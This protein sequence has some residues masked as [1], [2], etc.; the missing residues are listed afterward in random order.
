MRAVADMILQL[1]GGEL[2][3][4]VQEYP[5][6]QQQH[7]VRVSLAQING[8]L[9]TA[10]TESEV[11]EVFTQLDLPHTESG[12]E[13]EVQPPVERLDLLIAEDL[14]EEVARIQG[15]DRIVSVELSPVI[16]KPA[17]NKNFYYS[18]R[19]RRLLIEKGFSEIFSP[20]FTA[21]GE[22]AVL[23]KVES[24]TPFLRRDLL[25]GLRESLDKNV[26]NKD[27]FGITQVKLFEI[28]TVWR[29]GEESVWL[30][31]AVEKVK[32]E[33]TS[34]DY[35]KEV[36]EQLGIIIADTLADEVLEIP[37]EAFVAALPEAD[38]YDAPG[39]LPETHYR[40]FSRYP[41]IVRDIALWTPAETKPEEVLETIRSASGDLLLR[42]S[43]FDQFEKE[44]KV[45][46][47]YRLVFQSFDR[48][49]TDE[50]ANER[51]ESV[52]HAVEKKGWE[53]R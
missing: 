30:G 19:I 48:T 28:G 21:D 29:D 39:A 37:L 11:S 35:L 2:V 38:A 7:P 50:D 1:A 46:Y 9:G 45:S 31:V 17:I 33:K 26:R 42:I 24:D 51:M 25:G 18:E 43:L 12:G 16:E 32:K 14:I 49:L 23:N 10:F 8:A 15:Y 5:A 6:R 53:V 4:F 22:V 41:F 27:L 3:G 34:L 52:N 20:V 40:P 47:A 36:G 13:F 44:G